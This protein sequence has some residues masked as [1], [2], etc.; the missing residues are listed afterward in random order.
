MDIIGKWKY[1]EVIASMEEPDRWVPIADFV[2]DHPDE[3]FE[4]MMHQ[5]IEFTS[6]G[7]MITRLPK[8]A[9]PAEAAEEFADAE[10]EDGMVVLERSGWK[11]EDGKFYMHDDNP[12]EICGEAASEWIEL[13]VEDGKIELMAMFRLEKI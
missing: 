7:E 1:A 4:M 11:E 5:T 2:R 12:G 8:D 10:A 13:P 9:L 3:M 6:D